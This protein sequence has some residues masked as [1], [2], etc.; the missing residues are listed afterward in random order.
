[1]CITD[2]LCLS[3]LSSISSISRTIFLKF[4]S[5]PLSALFLGGGFLDVGI[6][7]WSLT[8]IHPCAHTILYVQNKPELIYEYHPGNLSKRV[9][10]LFHNYENYQVDTASSFCKEVI[11]S[12]LSCSPRK[13]YSTASSMAK[14]FNWTER[15]ILVFCGIQQTTGQKNMLSTV[16]GCQWNLDCYPEHADPFF[17]FFSI[18]QLIG[19]RAYTP[20]Q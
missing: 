4:S 18:F 5:A 19:F 6:A 13:A 3:S 1:M 2:Y 17:F 11:S 16:L 14:C 15:L 20:A 10:L 9:N 12:V 8:H 7:P